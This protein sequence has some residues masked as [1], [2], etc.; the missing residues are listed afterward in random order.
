MLF[1]VPQE[2]RHLLMQSFAHDR[3][4]PQTSPLAL[5]ASAVT[6]PISAGAASISASVAAPSAASACTSSAAL[7]SLSSASCVAAS[8]SGASATS[9][10]AS[11][12]RPRHWLRKPPIDV[13]KPMPAAFEISG[14]Q[15]R[16]FEKKQP[17][18]CWL[19]QIALFAPFRPPRE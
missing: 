14:W 13:G 15:I 7:D 6:S 2:E 8:A 5:S 1:N 3:A 12:F 10:V 19:R 11:S 16:R 4:T 9:S 17:K 18:A